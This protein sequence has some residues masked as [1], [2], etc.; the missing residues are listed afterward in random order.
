MPV[1]HPSS[2]LLWSVAAGRQTPAVHKIVLAHASM[3]PL[4]RAQLDQLEAVGG[5]LLEDEGDSALSEGALDRALVAV[6][7]ENGASTPAA[8]P[9]WLNTVPPAVREVVAE[10]AR[11]PTHAASK[12]VPSFNLMQT[13]AA[14]R[15]T[16][17]LLRIEPGK[18][19]AAHAHDGTEFVLVLTGAFRDQRGI[20][21]PGDLAVSDMRH[22][23]RPVAESGEAC[24][25]LIVTTAP[26]RFKG[27]LGLLQRVMTLGRG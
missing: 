7:A 26:L 23:H 14:N 13:M 9:D 5:A 24:L 1:H 17:E 6:A 19:I 2:D 20:F 3:C 4:C 8:V 12:G 16:M 25:A 22:T 15:E 10:A 21:A 27:P 11:S 18:A